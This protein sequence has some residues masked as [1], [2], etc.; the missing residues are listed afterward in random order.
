MSGRPM[1]DHLHQERSR[2]SSNSNSNTSNGQG[3]G[4]GLRNH[5]NLNT[6][7]SPSSLDPSHLLPSPI[8]PP[9]TTS[10]SQSS[11]ITHRP[12]S[13]VS[14]ASALSAASAVSSHHHRGEHD[15]IRDDLSDGAAVRKSHSHSISSNPHTLASSKGSLSAENKERQRA[16]RTLPRKDAQCLPLTVTL[17]AIYCT[18]SFHV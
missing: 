15:R 2:S 6:A 4:H 1:V 10:S 12:L 5:H 18:N 7:T 14:A 11:S 9:P 16:V 13:G 17:F 8:P 3:H